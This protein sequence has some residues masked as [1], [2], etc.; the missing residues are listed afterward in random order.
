MLK[1][2]RWEG[3]VDV[4]S[5]ER[6][7]NVCSL[8][9]SA[10]DSRWISNSFIFKFCDILAYTHCLFNDVLSHILSNVEW[11]VLARIEAFVAH[12]E[13]LCLYLICHVGIWVVISMFGRLFWCLSCYLGNG[14]ILSVFEPLSRHWSYYVGVSAVLPRVPVELRPVLPSFGSGYPTWDSNLNPDILNRNSNRSL[15]G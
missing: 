3:Q 14:A 7:S 8:R 1:S 12:F 4:G 15:P 5:T 11:L 10:T 2:D 9:V 6:V 13:P